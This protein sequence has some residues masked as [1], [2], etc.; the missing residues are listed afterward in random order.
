[1]N[2]LL[3]AKVP[4]IHQTIEVNENGIVTKLSDWYE[5]GKIWYYFELERA[6]HGFIS[7]QGTLGGQRT[8]I[9]GTLT[10]LTASYNN[11]DLPSLFLKRTPLKQ[12]DLEE[13]GFGHFTLIERQQS[14]AA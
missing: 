5:I 14:L 11:S 10:E 6:P 13:L 4:E 2:D 12:E 7:H 3:S 1:M 9:R 8:P